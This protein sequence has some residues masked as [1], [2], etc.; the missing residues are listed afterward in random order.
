MKVVRVAPDDVV[1]FE[2]VA[3][4]AASKGL[5]FRAIALN[6]VE[7]VGLGVALSPLLRAGTEQFDAVWVLTGRLADTETHR[8]RKT[9]MASAES[10]AIELLTAKPRPMPA[11]P[12]KDAK[13]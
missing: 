1:I 3:D 10:R 7:T 2:W 12:P 9:A 4:P 11:V 6:A 8:D 5:A 13:K